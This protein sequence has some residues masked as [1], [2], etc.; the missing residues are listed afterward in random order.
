MNKTLFRKSGLLAGLA[1]LA[2]CLATP[3]VSHAQISISLVQSN[4]TNNSATIQQGTSTFS[5]DLILNT[6]GNP[7][8]GFMYHIDTSP[9]GLFYG[10][11][12]LTALN[13]PFMSGD[14]FQEPAPGAM[15]NQGQGTTT[16]FKSSPG[17]YAA[18]N[19]A[20]IRHQFN[21]ASLAPGTY[22][23]NPIAQEFTNANG[24][25]L[26]FGAPGEFTLTVIP[27]PTTVA[28]GI[29]GGGMLLIV[30]RRQRRS[31]RRVEAGARA[32]G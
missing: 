6:D 30:A 7:V 31:K 32:V 29:V 28:L 25:I 16:L 14:V 17:D 1:T 3:T 13:N 22:V 19:N 2:L 11:T 27:E 24:S 18:F 12:P 5:L 8:S 21:T 26:T 4:T 20:I 9:V 15:V 10:A 23:F